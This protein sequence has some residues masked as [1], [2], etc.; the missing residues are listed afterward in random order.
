[1]NFER[2]KLLF[3]TRKDTRILTSWRPVLDIAGTVHDR[4]VVTVGGGT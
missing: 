3:A 4:V 2:T 1:M